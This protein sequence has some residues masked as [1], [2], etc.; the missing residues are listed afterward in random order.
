MRF[1]SVVVPLWL[2]AIDQRVAHVEAEPEAGQLGRGDRVDVETAVAELV[3]H[4]G[5]ALAGDRRRALPDDDASARIV[6]AAQPLGDRRRK[7]SVADDGAQPA[8]A[9]DDLAA[10]RLAEALAAPRRSP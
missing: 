4:R 6:P 7:A 1:V 3:E 5:R 8:V 10:Q 2:T 9:L